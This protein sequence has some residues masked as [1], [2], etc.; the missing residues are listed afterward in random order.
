[1]SDE[2][3]PYITLTEYRCPCCGA[4]PPDLRRDGD[5][6]WPGIY[7]A[8]FSRFKNIRDSF[9]GPINISSAY[10]CPAHNKKVGGAGLSIHLWG[11]ALDCAVG[12]DKV[13]RLVTIVESEHPEMRMG[14]SKRDGFCHL[15]VGYLIYPRATA[16]WVE[17][18]RWSYGD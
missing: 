10:R 6:E 18:A 3:A 13:D 11:L 12:A 9:G 1:M 8:L 14:V 2:I 5:M 4:V 17:S 7:E 16:D 15:D